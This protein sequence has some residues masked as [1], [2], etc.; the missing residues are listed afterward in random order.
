MARGVHRKSRR[1]KE[2]KNQGTHPQALLMIQIRNFLQKWYRGSAVSLLTSRIT[3]SRQQRR[4]EDL[5]KHSVYTHFPKDRNCGVCKRTKITRAPCRKR[6]AEAAH[7]AENFG[8]LI[9]ADHKVLNADGESR[10]NH[11]YVVVV[12][13]SATQWIHKTSLETGRSLR[14]FLEPSE[15]PKVFY[16]DNPL[17]FG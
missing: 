15:K 9:T 3:K 14:K 1:V 13:D 4:R 5:S 17:E 7:R 6:T 11:R 12:Q 2:S 8:Y 16:T 10:K